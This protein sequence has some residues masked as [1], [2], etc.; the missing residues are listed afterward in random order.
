MS[1]M[2][3]NFNQPGNLKN[4]TMGRNFNQDITLPQ[5]LESLTMGYCFNQSILFPEEILINILHYSNI[6]LRSWLTD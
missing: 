2:G 1:T 4:L 6:F 3:L 5:S